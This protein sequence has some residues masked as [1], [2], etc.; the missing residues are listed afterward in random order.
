M[1]IL[2]AR[3]EAKVDRSG[4]HHIWT[5]AR[6]ADGFGLM[7]ANGKPTTARRVAWELTNGPLPPGA[8]V[9]ACPSDPACVRVD[10]LSLHGAGPAEVARPARQRAPQGSGTASECCSPQTR[11]PRY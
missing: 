4:E 11:T 5:G 9:I 3:F 6:Y 7:K 8:R 10:H 1:P 2:A